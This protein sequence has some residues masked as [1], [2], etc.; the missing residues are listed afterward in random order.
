MSANNEK[1]LLNGGVEFECCGE[2]IAGDSLTATSS[3]AERTGSLGPML[4]GPSRT[5]F[6]KANGKLVKLVTVMTGTEIR[7]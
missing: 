2:I 6:T 7:D 3:I 4:I 5:E 1:A